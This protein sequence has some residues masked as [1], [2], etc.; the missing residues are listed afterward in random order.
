[1]KVLLMC[2][3]VGEVEVFSNFASWWSR[4]KKDR[5]LPDEVLQSVIDRFADPAVVEVADAAAKFMLKEVRTV[6]HRVD[7]FPEFIQFQRKVYKTPSAKDL[8]TWRALATANHT[9]PCPDGCEVQH[10]EECEH[11]FATWLEILEVMG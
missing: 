3:D 4:M 1:M 6:V 2:E 10:L 5:D 9:I 11:H 7:G 8:D